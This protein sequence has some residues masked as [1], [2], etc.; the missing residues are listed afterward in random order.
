MSSFWVRESKKTTMTTEA[1][2]LHKDGNSAS[3]NAAKH[4]IQKAQSGVEVFMQM[5]ES[6]ALFSSFNYINVMCYVF[7][8]FTKKPPPYLTSHFYWLHNSV[9]WSSVRAYTSDVYGAWRSHCS[10]CACVCDFECVSVCQIH[11][12]TEAVSTWAR[13]FSLPRQTFRGLLAFVQSAVSGK[14]LIHFF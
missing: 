6:K 7:R 8:V 11:W 4:L 10:A 14:H 3:F 12:A 5:Q 9:D 2:P 13:H 1:S